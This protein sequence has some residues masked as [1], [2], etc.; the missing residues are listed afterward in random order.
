V[1]RQPTRVFVAGATG[2]IG[3]QLV[4][5]LVAAG[6]EVA[7]TTRKQAKLEAIRA[8]GA[9]PVPLDALD[10]DQVLAAVTAYKPD[11]IV[12]ELTDL[13]GLEMRSFAKDFEVTNQLRTRGTDNL[14]GAGRNVGV[15]RFIAQSYAGWP[16][17]RTGSRIKTEDEPL[18]PQPAAVMRV[19]F[20]AIGYVERTTLAA[21]WTEGIVLRYG[22]FYGPGAGLAADGNQLGLLRKRRWPLIGNSE[23]VWSFIHVA[24]AAEATVAAIERGS[25]GIYHVVEDDPPAAAEWLPVVAKRLG[26]PPPLRVPLWLGRLLGGEAA[27]IVMTEIRGAS[28]AKAKRD[29]GW[30]PKHNWRVDLGAAD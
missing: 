3:R 25:R 13:G 1:S 2:A 27:A 7:G 21:D 26:A 22:S 23:G 29:L 12:H 28:N 11:V 9:T 19:A 16:F 18:D 15:R 10:R 17:A 6:Y 4:P 5:R 24:D 30:Q 14:L 8:M 20:D